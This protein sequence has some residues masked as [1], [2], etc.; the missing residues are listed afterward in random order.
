M[1]LR[2]DPISI[3]GLL[4]ALYLAGFLTWQHF[5]NKKEQ[6]RG[7]QLERLENDPGE[8]FRDMCV[9]RNHAGPRSGDCDERGGVE[10]G[11][12]VSLEGIEATEQR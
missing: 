4:V 10:S 2:V 5:D 1:T 3:L 12:K 9:E 11:G 6:R 8:R 7:V